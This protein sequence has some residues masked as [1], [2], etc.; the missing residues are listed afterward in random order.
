MSM[1]THVIGL[2]TDKDETYKKHLKVLKACIEADIEKL[3]AETAKYF[4]C[5]YPEEYLAEEAL[6]VEMPTKEWSNS[7]SSGYEIKV[8]EIPVGVE[9]IRFS[10]SW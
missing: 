10:N 2:R 8:S 6:T 9:T 3:P 7:H 5:E 4:D 1:S